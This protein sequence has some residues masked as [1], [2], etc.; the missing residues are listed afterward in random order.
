MIWNNDVSY[1]SEIPYYGIYVGLDPET[2]TPQ[3]LYVIQALND[4]DADRVAMSIDE[5]FIIEKSEIASIETIMSETLIER[6]KRIW[7]F[8]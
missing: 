5:G 2:R 7:S 1:N 4:V 8:Q 6:K 3:K